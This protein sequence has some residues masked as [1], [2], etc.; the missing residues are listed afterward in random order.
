MTPAMPT[1]NDDYHDARPD[2]LIKFQTIM[3]KQSEHDKEFRAHREFRESTGVDL[4]TLATKLDGQSN[5][6]TNLANSIEKTN[7]LMLGI[8]L[9]ILGTAFGFLIWYIQSLPR[10]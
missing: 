1:Y 4:A 3:D 6:I 9:S 10:A 2:C 7:K 8:L 5:S